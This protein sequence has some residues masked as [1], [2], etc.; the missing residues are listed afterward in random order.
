MYLTFA[1]GNS[2]MKCLL[3]LQWRVGN[4]NSSF[5]A[6][7]YSMMMPLALAFLAASFLVFPLHE[8]ETKAKQVGAPLQLCFVQN[9]LI[10]FAPLIHAF[11]HNKAFTLLY[12]H[13]G[14]P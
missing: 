4:T 2:I 13:L 3:S 1:L 5:S 9:I 7:M 10:N 6:L 12:H 11:L 8:R 14:H